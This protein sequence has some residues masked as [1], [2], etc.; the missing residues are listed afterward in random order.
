[1]N[2][3]FWG[4]AISTSICTLL[5]VYKVF[6]IDMELEVKLSK[7]RLEAEKKALQT[8]QSQLTIEDKDIEDDP[9]LQ[10]LMDK[11]NIGDDTCG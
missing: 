11:D 5:A 8:L 4:A 10:P 2:G 1:M 9:E 6:E 3:L 7:E